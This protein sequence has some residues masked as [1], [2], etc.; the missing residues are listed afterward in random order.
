VRK[1]KIYFRPEP[2][3]TKASGGRAPW[4]IKSKTYEETSGMQRV[5][6]GLHFGCIFNAVIGWL[7]QRF[8]SNL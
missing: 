3:S 6:G 2:V 4:W 8:S 7:R 5:G 1:V